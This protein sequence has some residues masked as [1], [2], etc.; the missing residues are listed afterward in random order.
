MRIYEHLYVYCVLISFSACYNLTFS[1]LY[2]R[3]CMAKFPCHRSRSR[4]R[5]LGAGS[6]I[7]SPVKRKRD[8][9]PLLSLFA[10]ILKHLIPPRCL[11]SFSVRRT[12]GTTAL[13]SVNSGSNSISCIARNVLRLYSRAP[14]LKHASALCFA[15]RR[16]YGVIF[17]SRE[18]E[19]RG[20]HMGVLPFA[21]QIRRGYAVGRHRDL[22][23]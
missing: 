15:H 17:G 10:R 18:F 9:D 22:R 16:R 7:I 12:S 23:D 8:R 14:E 5:P 2:A 21:Q 1:L 4:V 3:D 19:R 6:Q 11:P 13:S 20:A